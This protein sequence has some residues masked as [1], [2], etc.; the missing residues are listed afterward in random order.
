M[1]D[2]ENFGGMESTVEG[3]DD[4][5]VGAG[6]DLTQLN[7]LLKLY[8]EMYEIAKPFADKT[9][10]ITAPDHKL[11]INTLS[12][13]IVKNINAMDGAYI[14]T[15]RYTEYMKV[16]IDGYKQIK[17]KINQEKLRMNNGLR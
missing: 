2:P 16:F 1:K 9:G 12:P 6:H 7:M 3:L 4:M 8:D 13:E 14:D 10:K 15:L 17:S 5:I 11:P